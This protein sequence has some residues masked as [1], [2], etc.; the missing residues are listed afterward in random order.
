MFVPVQTQAVAEQLGEL[1]VSLVATLETQYQ[2]T[3]QENIRNCTPFY[4]VN[5]KTG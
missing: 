2:N 4:S 5:I 1:Q 3:R